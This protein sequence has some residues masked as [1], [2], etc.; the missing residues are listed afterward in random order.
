[1]NAGDVLKLALVA[2]IVIVALKLWWRGGAGGAAGGGAGPRAFD[3]EWFDDQHHA[4][5]YGGD[6]EDEGYGEDDDEG[7]DDETEEFA[8]IDE[9]FAVA[10]ARGSD[11]AFSTSADL[12]P[13]P[14]NKPEFKITNSLLAQNF[15]ECSRFV[16]LDTQGSSLRNANHDLRS[17]PVIPRRDVGPWAQ[18]TIEADLLRKPLE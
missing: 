17:A 8:E 15:L 12:L 14:A 6:M 7:Y 9:D 18:S 3:G 11:G 1:M 10:K 4:E 5:G 2:A 13:P 16:G